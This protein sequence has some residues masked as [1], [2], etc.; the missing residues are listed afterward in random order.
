MVTIKELK[1]AHDIAV[2][3]TPHIRRG[4]RYFLDQRKKHFRRVK[5]GKQYARYKKRTGRALVA[6]G[7]VRS[8]T[9][10]GR[11]RS[12]GFS[13]GSKFRSHKSANKAKVPQR[14]K[15]KAVQL[16]DRISSISQKLRASDA[17]HTHRYLECNENECAANA[18]NYATIDA[19]TIAKL[20]GALANLRYYNP[21]VPGTLTTADGSTGSYNRNFYFK[22][23]TSSI[24]FR[25]NYET[26]CNFRV[27]CC[28]PRHDT[29]ITPA[30]A[31]TN[32][33]T[34]QGAPTASSTVIY[35]T[36]SEQF[37][38][39]WT[40][41]KSWTKTLSAGSYF[42]CSYANKPFFYDPSNTDSHALAYQSVYG[43][44]TWFVR[45]QGEPSHASGAGS[46]GLCAAG[47]DYWMRNTFKI[48]YDAGTNLE[49]YSTSESVTGGTL[50]LSNKPVVEQQGFNQGA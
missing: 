29:S 13:K 20:E 44:L 34:D 2:F 16:S 23:T 19:F 5:M 12:T 31:M 27:Y 3:A 49:D 36:D 15:P 17:T 42:T 37:R 18:T 14:A 41:K 38:A 11:R 40:I 47:Y 30:G 39:L 26:V 28:V 48:V 25:N 1:Q 43:G 35:P 46:A 50:L 32:G 8:Y 6:V 7:G 21:A 22:S 45:I 33:L 10:S 24:K 9:K 4:A